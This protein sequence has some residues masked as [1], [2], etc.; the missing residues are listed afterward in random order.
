LV[1]AVLL[2]QSDTAAKDI[3][4]TVLP[5]EADSSPRPIATG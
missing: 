4:T 1:W 3:A 2:V 5:A